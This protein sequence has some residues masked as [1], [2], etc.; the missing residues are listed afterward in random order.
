MRNCLV[1]HVLVLVFSLSGAL[2]AS[3]FWVSPDGRDTNTGSKESPL[4]SP[5]IALRRARELRRLSPT[6][7]ENG[8]HI[9]LRTG[10]YRLGSTL[11]IRPEDSG[12]E[13]SPT[14][15]EAAP[16]EKP[17]ISGG[18]PL[19]N[20][21]KVEG[22]ISG[23]PASAVGHVWVA[24][25]PSFNGQL[26]EFRQL[27]VDGHKAIRAR[28]PNAPLMERLV[29]WDR[30]KETA[31]IPATLVT[32]LPSAS[33]IEMVLAQQWAIAFLRLRDFRTDGAQTLITF[34]QPES[35]I[36]FE[37]PWPQPILASEGGSGAFFLAN[38]IEF[39]D[40]PG[41]WFHDLQNRRVYYWPRDGE[42][43]E[44]ADVIVPAL[45]TL[46]EI[47]G[48]LDRPV[49]HVQ[50]RGIQFQNTTWLRPS[51]AGHVPLQAGLFIT[52]SY[53]LRPKGTPDWRSL[54]NQT[55]TGRP[56]AGVVVKGATHVR[57]ERC[58]IEHMAMSGLDFATG[59]QDEVVEGCVFRDIGNN[60][61]QLGSFQDNGVES[62]LPYNPVDEREICARAR[63][64]NNILNDCANED[65]GGVAIIAGYVRD[66][67]IEHN[68]ISETSYTGI[69]VGWGWT[70][71]P[72]VM[73]RNRIHAN[74]FDR[75]ATRMCDDAAIYTLSAQPG[76]SIYENVISEIKMSPYVDRPDHWFYLYT[77][78]GS[79]FI[80]VRDNWCFH[81]KFLQN[82]NGPGNVWENNGP[83][84]SEEIR[85]AAG[86]EP[87]FR[88]IR[89]E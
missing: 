3:E 24:D 17:I 57:F 37:H 33:G 25:S 79:S 21:R 7:P 16:G 88:E 82:A 61:V 70:R 2:N 64:S 76:S 67:T 20:W 30:E 71:S 74:R 69:S 15:I 85:K 6:A 63:I 35:R 43:L 27:W 10:T 47:T 54:D 48:T 84:V 28:T 34:H 9:L 19:T 89:L 68:E 18:I 4:A 12:T 52:E 66:T 44:H 80:T 53:K 81:A 45:E 77:D 41:E 36:E 38:A 42:N 58:R 51:S 46:L 87:S 11:V 22:N 50:V 55:W 73:R 75:I 29:S 40:A 49:S 86:L 60:G 14:M 62:H 31:G 56:P 32:G 65:W 5:A 83:Q 8:L 23:L 59:T 13:A 26:L 78:E 39:L 1:A 72:N